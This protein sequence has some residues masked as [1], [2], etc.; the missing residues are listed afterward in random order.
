MGADSW[1]ETGRNTGQVH[2]L[3]EYNWG[4]LRPCKR[5]YQI[6]ENKLINI[7]PCLGWSTIYIFVKS[8]KTVI[9]FDP[10]SYMI[11]LRRTQGKTQQQN[12]NRATGLLKNIDNTYI[13]IKVL[14]RKCMDT[15]KRTSPPSARLV[16][17]KK[18]QNRILLNILETHFIFSKFH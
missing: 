1:E 2:V 13:R 15:L 18:L 10:S 5:I 16:C 8:T 14:K 3:E 6:L 12:R 11:Q 7:K 17:N 4:R 9:L